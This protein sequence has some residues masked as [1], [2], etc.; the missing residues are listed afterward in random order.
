MSSETNTSI[1]IKKRHTRT[2]TFSIHDEESVKQHLI[3][4]NI[5]LSPIPHTHTQMRTRKRNHN[6]MSQTPIH[7][8]CG[9]CWTILSW[10]SA[11]QLC[12]WESVSGLYSQQAW[13][14]DWQALLSCLSV[15]VQVGVSKQVSQQADWEATSLCFTCGTKVQTACIHGF[16]SRAEAI[17]IHSPPGLVCLVHFKSICLKVLNICWI[18]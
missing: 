9:T 7:N 12:V 5:N 1:R 11:A 15:Y 13:L 14:T 3:I 2:Q 8:A 6:H 10:W 17:I 18:Y 16:E 4:E